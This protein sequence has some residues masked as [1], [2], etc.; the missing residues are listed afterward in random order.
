MPKRRPARRKVVRR[1]VPKPE[2]KKPRFPI[3]YVCGREVQPFWDKE[4][5]E[6]RGF[7]V[8]IPASKKYPEGL[9]RHDACAP[10]TVNY[11]DNPKL[12]KI[13]ATAVGYRTVREC[14][15]ALGIG[16]KKKR[17]RKEVG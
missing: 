3:C 15:R 13:F 9:H 4:K 12:A 7:G 6:K 8:G 11:M 1:P 14:R 10:G 2:P 17:K 5:E 16:R